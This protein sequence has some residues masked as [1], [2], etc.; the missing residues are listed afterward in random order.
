MLKEKKDFVQAIKY[1]TMATLSERTQ[2]AA[3]EFLSGLYHDLNDSKQK[4]HWSIYG[5]GLG[6]ASCCNNLATEKLLTGVDENI[7]LAAA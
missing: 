5:Q 3:V 1:L 7:A 4:N 6:I 2:Y